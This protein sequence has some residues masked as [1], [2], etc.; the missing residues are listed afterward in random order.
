[1]LIFLFLAQNAEQVKCHKHLHMTSFVRLTVRYFC[2]SHF[3]KILRFYTAFS[4]QQ[5]MAARRI[6]RTTGNGYSAH[7]HLVFTA[8][9]NYTNGRKGNKN[10]RKFVTNRLRCILNQGLSQDL[11]ECSGFCG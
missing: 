8:L 3:V 1:M 6:K 7:F 9:R 11:E 5:N 4:V 10:Y 2:G